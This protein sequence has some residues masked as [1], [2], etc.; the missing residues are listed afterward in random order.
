[1]NDLVISGTNSDTVKDILRKA[2]ERQI[3]RRNVPTDPKLVQWRKGKGGK[4]FKYV[5]GMTAQRWL[6]E[7]FPLWGFTITARWEDHDFV[8]VSGKLRVIEEEGVIREVEDIGCDEIEH[9]DGKRL[10]LM[11]WKAARTDAL[12]RCAVNLGAFTDVYSD[13]ELNLKILSEEDMQWYKDMLP[14]LLNVLS[15]KALF[16]N[17]SLFASGELSKE[18]ILS[19]FK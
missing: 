10:E 8:Y 6:D 9:K 14:N 5:E 15:A 13:E 11:Y 2:K 3:H 17:M 4:D 7:N 18:D 12:K 19:I 16:A 1:M